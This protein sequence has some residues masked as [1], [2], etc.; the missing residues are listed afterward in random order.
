MTI[1]Q[2]W[3]RVALDKK[4]V[5]IIAG[6]AIVVPI[7]VQVVTSELH[8]R[9]VGQ[10][11]LRIR[12]PSTEVMVQWSGFSA[13]NQNGRDFGLETYEHK[14]AFTFSVAN[15]GDGKALDVELLFHIPINVKDIIN[16]LNASHV[17]PDFRMQ[18]N[19]VELYTQR[20]KTWRTYSLPIG[21]DDTRN[22]GTLSFEADHNEVQIVYPPKIQ[23]SMLLWLFSKS[24]RLTQMERRNHVRDVE[25]FQHLM[26]HDLSD[27]ATQARLQQLLLQGRTEATIE[28][29][30]V[31]VK[32]ISHDLVG[33]E[34]AKM[35]TVRA[36]YLAGNAFWVDDTEK[37]YSYFDGGWGIIAYEKEENSLEGF[38]NAYKN[39]RR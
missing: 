6:L 13:N 31:T 10:P 37:E 34:H 11:V 26:S 32:I 25:E 29:P 35:A 19:S 16:E 5:V 27:P 30:T 17:F 23:N 22:L 3:K 9:E 36:I 4:L 15:V 28:C 8:R 33:V 21:N 14:S 18:G 24:Y 7:L 2:R 12:P 1:W 20:G 38:Y 39:Q